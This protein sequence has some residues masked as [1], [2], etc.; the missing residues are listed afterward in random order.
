MDHWWSKCL[1]VWIQGRDMNFKEDISLFWIV[2]PLV[3]ISWVA[4]AR[5]TA[6]AEKDPLG[7]LSYTFLLYYY[8][9][10]WISCCLG[11]A[12]QEIDNSTM[13][14]RFPLI[15]NS[16]TRKEPARL[17]FSATIAYRVRYFWYSF[18]YELTFFCEGS[19]LFDGADCCIDWERCVTPFCDY[20][21]SKAMV[22]K[23]KGAMIHVLSNHHFKGKLRWN[24]S[25]R[26]CFPGF[27]FLSANRFIDFFAYSSSSV[28]WRYTLGQARQRFARPS[29]PLIW[30][31]ESS[32]K[33][34]IFLFLLFLSSFFLPQGSEEIPLWGG[35][36]ATICRTLA[37]ASLAGEVS[38]T[39][40]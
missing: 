25:Q 34:M 22:V 11:E 7:S 9:V 8:F 12:V 39:I 35:F 4:N 20:D 29:S 31:S 14:A 32:K 1:L 40:K 16:G 10:H 3:S 24:T 36:P 18:W 26:S 37:V 13:T 23:I 33:L 5:Q 38:F 15:F 6:E 19:F 28:T 21:K 27:S 30:K 17:R 2:F